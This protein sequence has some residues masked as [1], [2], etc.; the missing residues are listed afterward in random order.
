MN[1][2]IFKNKKKKKKEYI[3]VT[4]NFITKKKKYKF[5]DNEYNWYHT[6]SIINK[7]LF[8]FCY[9]QKLTHQFIMSI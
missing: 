8:I 5:R 9:V 1:V 2:K 6:N 3:K 4:M 7:F